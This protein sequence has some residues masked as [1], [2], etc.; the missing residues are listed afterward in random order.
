MLNTM[1]Q[2]L[3]ND[4]AQTI[5]ELLA[6]GRYASQN[7]VLRNALAALRQRDADRAAI[8]AGLADV[9]AGRYR[10]FAEGDV[11]F[12]ARHNIVKGT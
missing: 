12:R 10:A 5:Q 9:A 6:T 3:A 11:E 7:D 8:E 4:V 2:I 1:S